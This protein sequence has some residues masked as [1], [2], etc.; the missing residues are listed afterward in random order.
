M[1]IHDIDDFL[2]PSG[3]FTHKEMKHLSHGFLMETVPL[4]KV[5]LI[6]LVLVSVS[7][8]FI[9]SYWQ[10]Y[11]QLTCENYPMFCNET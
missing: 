2:P 11:H 1:K 10:D 9:W 5:L 8:L 7:G 6:T 4:W 3:G